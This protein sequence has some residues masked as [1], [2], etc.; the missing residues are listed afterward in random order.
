MILAIA[1]QLKIWAFIMKA[2]FRLQI[3]QEKTCKAW[4]KAKGRFYT[5]GWST[6][7]GPMGSL[8]GYLDMI[9]WFPITP[10]KW[11]S[12]E[13]DLWKLQPGAPMGDVTNQIRNN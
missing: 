8:I 1:D 9:G 11:R 5:K 10:F 7:T 13:G 3:D 4:W 12:P 6:V 2:R